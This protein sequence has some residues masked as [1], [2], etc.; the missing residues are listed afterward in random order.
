M[1]AN[2]VASKSHYDIGAPAT[3]NAMEG[4]RVR[5][6]RGGKVRV[7]VTRDVMDPPESGNVTF[8]MQVAPAQA[9][10]QPGTFIA[11]TSGNNLEAITNEVV[12]PGQTKSYE[13]LIR[14][15]IDAF[16]LFKCSG[17]A[18]VQLQLEHDDLLDKWN[19]VAGLPALTEV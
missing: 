17:G 4:W 1:P 5:K 3:A 8:S 15:N 10:G 12:G 19:T 18:R 16:V 13:I 7:L 14:P 6:N 9:S 2:Q 11:T